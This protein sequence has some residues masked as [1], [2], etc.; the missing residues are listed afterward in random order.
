MHVG[1]HLMIVV[2]QIGAKHIILKIAE[3]L[4]DLLSQ[5]ESLESSEFRTAIHPTAVPN[6]YVMPSGGVRHNVSSLLYSDRLAEVIRIARSEFDMIL[7]DTPP[8][9]NISDARVL[10]R[11]VDGVI[12]VVRSA[13]T[14]RDAALLAKQRFTDDGLNVLGTILNGWNP[15]T[16][17][18]GY[19]RYYY[20]GYY[21]YY[22]S[23]AEK[24]A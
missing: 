1:H 13:V 21:H 2:A 5:R 11:F 24:E 15:N 7:I 12:L 19:Y 22:G 20:A 14:T 18:Y 8:M 9:V 4:S 16:P 10:A 17:G 23:P 3:R 6:L